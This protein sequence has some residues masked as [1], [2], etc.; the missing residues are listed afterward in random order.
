MVRNGEQERTWFRS[1][2]FLHIGDKWYFVTRENTQKGPFDSKD[3]AERELIL[4]LRHAGDDFYRE[5]L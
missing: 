3:E 4:Y 2:R 5:A 1:E